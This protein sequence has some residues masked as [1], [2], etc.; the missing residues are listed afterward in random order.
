MIY[1]IINMS[2]SYTIKA[3]S[4]DVAAVACLLLGSG[5]YGFAPLEDGGVKI[6]LFMFGGVDEWFREHFGKDVG[7]CVEEIRE[8][9]AGE[10]ADCL[11]SC[12]IGSL[13]DR[14][15]YERELELI[16]SPES[17]E[18][19][20]AERHDKRRTSMNDI[21]GRA[22]EMAKRLREESENVLVPAPAQVFI[23]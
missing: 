22:Y 23:A 17:R 2:D 16:E 12:L 1:D 18:K 14:Q 3:E 21:G 5:Q 6:P 20:R 4:L 13:T 19:F 15:E 7:P 9:R 10:L 8:K 11:D